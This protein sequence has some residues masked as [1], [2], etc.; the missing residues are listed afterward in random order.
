M[1]SLL[2]AIGVSPALPFLQNEII[3]DIRVGK[4]ASLTSNESAINYELLDVCLQSVT[5]VEMCQKESVEAIVRIES[6]P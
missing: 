3:G 6:P 5:V 4:L 1:L 2:V